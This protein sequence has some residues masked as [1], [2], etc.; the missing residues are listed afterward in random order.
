MKKHLC[1][2]CATILLI[3]TSFLATGQSFE[4]RRNQFFLMNTI[5]GGIVSGLGSTIHKKPGQ[6]K[7][8]AFLIGFGKGCL[9]GSLQFAGKYMLG[10][11][12][13]ERDYLYAWPAK[14]VHAAGSSIVENGSRNKPIWYNFSMDYGPVRLDIYMTGQTTLRIMPVATGGILL[15]FLSGNTF[16]PG[17]TLRTGTFCFQAKDHPELKSG[18]N[19]AFANSIA[20]DYLKNKNQESFFYNPYSTTAHEIIHT[21][22]YREWLSVNSL[23]CK[24]KGKLIYWDFPV[25]MVPYIAGN[26]GRYAFDHRYYSNPFE[27]EAESLSRRHAV[28]WD[29]RDPS[30]WPGDPKKLLH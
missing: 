22:Q 17:Q 14:I 28:N 4:T 9:G 13:Q 18:R 24:N 15:H 29:V 3:L 21:Y 7:V 20:V 2:H 30:T 27:L 5:T 11:L 12:R 25:F 23:Y 6:T 19:I 26:I 16:L 10:D 8:Q 1:Y